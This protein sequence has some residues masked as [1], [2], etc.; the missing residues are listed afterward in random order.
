MSGGFSLFTPLVGTALMITA[1]LASVTIVQNDVRLSRSISTGYVTGSQATA[2][3]IILATIEVSTSEELQRTSGDFLL[4]RDAQR[5]PSIGSYAP[6]HVITCSGDCFEGVKAHF[7]GGDLPA[8][9]NGKDI[10]RGII[11]SATTSVGYSA[12]PDYSSLES[13]LQSATNKPGRVAFE[14]DGS[15]HVYIDT[16]ALQDCCELPLTIEFE[17]TASHARL[18]LKVIPKKAEYY[19]PKGLAQLLA[20]AAGGFGRIAN[21]GDVDAEWL[22]IRPRNA[23]PR[24]GEAIAS[25]MRVFKYAPDPVNS[26]DTAYYA[27]EFDISLQGSEAV[28]LVLK[29]A[30]YEFHTVS[31]VPSPP[32]PVDGSPPARS[33]SPAGCV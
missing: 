19:S 6:Y 3:K 32:E 2:A 8:T 25:M 17:D 11:D 26:P 7:E 9:L 23:I 4:G 5:F 22:L 33:C 18:K 31:G 12:A 16:A 15:L 24:E 20:R 10:Y 27:V 30:G 13:L 28:R 29:Q 14:P 1:I 21:G